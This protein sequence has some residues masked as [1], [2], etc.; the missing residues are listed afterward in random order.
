VSVHPRTPRSLPARRPSSAA[1]L[2]EFLRDPAATAS[3]VPSSPALA[4]RML[5]GLDLSACRTI[6]EFGP[7]T[8]VF[9]QEVLGRLPRGWL[10]SQGG[11][12][13]FI[14]VEFNGRLAETVRG[15]HPEIDV[16][17][18]DAANVEA[19]CR[20]H[21]VA[22][23]G[24]DLVIS[25]LG[26]AALPEGVTTRILEATSR[27]LRPGGSFRTFTY[28]VSLIK[29]QA[30]HFRSEARRLFSSVEVSRGVW[31]NLPP[32]FVYMCTK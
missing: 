2:R 30:W 7:G 23:G 22:P 28:H 31:A 18:D 4:R 19:I 6:V 9:T 13:T 3:V 21:G 12:G 16:E 10:R 20:R 32:A 11:R 5:S 27:V 1:F 8:G 24:V 25:G 26:F 29:K 17:H 15:E 14:A